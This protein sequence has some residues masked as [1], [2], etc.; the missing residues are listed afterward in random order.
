[1][2]QN[3]ADNKPVVFLDETWANAH[4]CK[5]WPGWKTILLRGGTL[6]GN[7]CPSGKGK[8]LSILGVGGEMGW[9]LNTTL[10]FQ[11]KKNTGDYHDE[12][13]GLRSGLEIVCSQM[14][15]LIVL[16]LWLRKVGLSA[17]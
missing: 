10:I 13:T 11:S 6:G 3:T 9:I 16:L 2:K 7:R 15:L 14:F 5:T 17:R 1:M 8:R 4:D 12:M